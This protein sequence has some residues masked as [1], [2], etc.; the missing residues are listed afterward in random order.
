MSDIERVIPASGAP[1]N[2]FWVGHVRLGVVSTAASSAVGIGYCLA[3]FS[4]PNRAMMIAIGSLA[5]IT[6]PLILSG[7]GMR[8]FTGAAR[9][10]WLYAWSASL[11][12]AV[13][14]ASALDEGA[15][16]P[17]V[18]LF[19]ASLV[20]TASGFGRA[21]AVV[22]GASTLACYLL[23]VTFGSPGTWQV[24]LTTTALAVI[25]ATCT[26]TSG[27]L[28]LS[29]TEQQRLTDELTVRVARD[30]L[31]GCLNH[32]ALIDRLELEVTRAHRESRSLGFVM[33]DLDDFK[34]AND[35]HG[36]VAGDELLT[37]LGAELN[38]AV[39]PYDLV[40]RVG[41]DEF[42][43]VVPNTEEGEVRRLA[44]RVRRR[45]TAV[46]SPLGVGISVGVAVL[47]PG[48]DARTLRQRADQA[49][50]ASKRSDPPR[51]TAI[52]DLAKQRVADNE[53]PEG[54]D[55]R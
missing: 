29:L 9:E 39:R 33:M 7:P 35:T 24:V 27:R 37:A 4:S 54:V 46:G 20:F 50:Y 32:S 2:A 8:A 49:L 51:S 31:T 21:G 10:L 13:T 30:G 23:T 11:L 34:A 43:I 26:L 14:T 52:A 48:D 5:M 36:H 38:Q 12:L 16:S 42:A 28:L 1:Q 41:G 25:A 45:L 15:R 44:D 55:Q 40:G 53:V 6:C 22:M 3:T 47:G 19:V 18:L 17:L